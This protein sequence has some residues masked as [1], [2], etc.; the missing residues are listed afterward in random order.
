MTTTENTPGSSIKDGDSIY[1]S[2]LNKEGRAEQI[3][4]SEYQTKATPLRF[5]SSNIQDASNSLTSSSV[6]QELEKTVAGI[7]EKLSFPRS[8]TPS[9]NRS[10]VNGFNDSSNGPTTH[11]GEKD[12]FI[13]NI[14][15]STLTSSSREFFPIL[16]SAEPTL[17]HTPIHRLHSSDSL[18][19]ASYCSSL[20][21]S[22][23]DK[24]LVAD[25]AQTLNTSTIDSDESYTA[26][27]IEDR[28]SKDPTKE[29]CLIGDHGEEDF[30]EQ[31]LEPNIKTVRFQ[32]VPS[33]DSSGSRNISSYEETTDF[34]GKPPYYEACSPVKEANQID[35]YAVNLRD[36]DETSRM[37]AEKDED[38]GS[39]VRLTPGD[40]QRK[41]RGSMMDTNEVKISESKGR[42]LKS[43]KS[44]TKSNKTNEIA[45][46]KK[47][48]YESPNRYEDKSL[49]DVV[50]QLS[51]L[52]EPEKSHPREPFSGSS[53]AGGIKPGFAATQITALSYL[54][55]ELTKVLSDRS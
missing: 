4:S 8:L 32:N 2:P 14:S 53:Y 40:E 37:S 26:D 48:F 47:Q 27:G 3:I 18:E 21:D 16:P 44:V 38:E 1:Q 29:T 11:E 36:K 23:C 6:F 30:V 52:K 45:T 55:R 12:N 41:R 39:A 25:S 15:S 34:T 33:L 5:E 7:S 50:S 35:P 28:S 13:P 24:T 17:A 43:D 20:S 54:F 19:E 31:R 22:E 42:K 46:N 49:M 51:C 10:S 9:F